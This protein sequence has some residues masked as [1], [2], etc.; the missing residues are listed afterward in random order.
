MKKREIANKIHH[1]FM[2][3]SNLKALHLFRPRYLL[4]YC[5]PG[6]GVGAAGLLS[7]RL[8]NQVSIHLLS[9]IVIII[10]NIDIENVKRTTK[11]SL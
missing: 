11:T 4:L 6:V 5:L 8:I 2:I 7:L 3:Q 1:H 10:A 9:L